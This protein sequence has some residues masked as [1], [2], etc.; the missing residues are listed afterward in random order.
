M[1]SALSILHEKWLTVQHS[2]FSFWGN[3]Q[4]DAELQEQAQQ[5]QAEQFEA[6]TK[7]SWL[8]A[9][10]NSATESYKAD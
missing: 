7:V 6:L 10:N 9:L 5:Q 8:H 4:S 1:G 2:F 3:G